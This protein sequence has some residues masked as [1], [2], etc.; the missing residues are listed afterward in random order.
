VGFVSRTRA[1]GFFWAAERALDFL[2]S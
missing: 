2:A 1:P